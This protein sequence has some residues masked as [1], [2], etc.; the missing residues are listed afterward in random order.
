MRTFKASEGFRGVLTSAE[1]QHM[2]KHP[3]E[4]AMEIGR[5]VPFHLQFMREQKAKQSSKKRRIKKM[6]RLTQSLEK[7][8]LDNHPDIIVLIMFG[9]LELFT[10]EMQQ[11]YIAWCQTDEGSQYLKGGKYYKETKEDEQ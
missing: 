2:E 7:W 9:H 8:F 10:I 5:Q 1:L 6:V 3:S 4:K 11:Q